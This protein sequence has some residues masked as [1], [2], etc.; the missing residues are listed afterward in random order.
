MDNLLKISQAMCGFYHAVIQDNLV[1]A[2]G[3]N[4][5]AYETLYNNYRSDPDMIDFMEDLGYA[6][7]IL[8]SNV[9]LNKPREDK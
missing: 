1:A 9:K 2:Q 6:G 4:Q 3:W 7:M 5:L 8:S